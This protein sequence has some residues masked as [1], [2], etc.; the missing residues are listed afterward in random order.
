MNI[1]AGRDITAGRDLIIT[2]GNA[3]EKE[4]QSDEVLATLTQLITQ[5]QSHNQEQLAAQLSEQTKQ[6]ASTWGN[7]VI[8][9]INAAGLIVADV[10]PLVTNL[11][12]LLRPS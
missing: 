11:L 6:P 10:K 5:L 2:E 7:H 1:N 4:N 8:D 9:L 3:G 12:H